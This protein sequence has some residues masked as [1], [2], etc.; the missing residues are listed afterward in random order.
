MFNNKYWYSLAIAVRTDK[1]GFEEWSNTKRWEK[2]ALL[3]HRAVAVAVWVAV[4]APADILF[5]QH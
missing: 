2:W 5:N 1:A 3:P 4:L